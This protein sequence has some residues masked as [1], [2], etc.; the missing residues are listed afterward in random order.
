MA[1]QPIQLSLNSLLNSEKNSKGFTL[2]EMLVVIV[3]IG[4]TSTWAV[5]AFNRSRAQVQVDNY[6]KNLEA[7]LFS[8]RSKM[9]VMKGSCPINFTRITGFSIGTFFSPSD[10]LEL[11]QP[12]GSRRS[13]DALADCK[14][15]SMFTDL[16]FDQNSLR[17]VNLEGSSESEQV[18]VASLSSGYSFNPPGTSANPS[19][20]IILIRSIRHNASWAQSQSNPGS[21]RLRTRC[22][23]ISGN[24]QIHSGT[25]LPG[26]Q[27]I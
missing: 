19:N 23:E 27:C 10:L 21:S 12:D 24:G 14:D 3:I 11:Q 13:A 16:A 7:G 25:W 20:L 4:L 6:A 8:L 18:Q 26:N 9:G 22:V 2:L 5:P 15:V 1:V 17:L